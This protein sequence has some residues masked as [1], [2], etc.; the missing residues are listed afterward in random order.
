MAH[1]NVSSHAYPAQ[2]LQSHP[3]KDAFVFMLQTEKYFVPKLPTDNR[4]CSSLPT[5]EGF[6]EN[7]PTEER[8]RL[9]ANPI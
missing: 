3:Q 7:V 5:K 9:G 8:K 4:N 6:C 2:K 1:M